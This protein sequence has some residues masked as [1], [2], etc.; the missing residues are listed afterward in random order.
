MQQAGYRVTVHAFD[1]EEHHPMSENHHGVRIMRY[2]VGRVAY[3]GTVGT[4][5]GIRR[6]LRTV[7]RTLVNDPPAFG[8]LPRR[9]YAPSGMRPQGTMRR[10]V[11]L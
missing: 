3:G 8:V 6:F 11:R 7:E 4:Y 5:R 2:R 9:R 1:R 10:P